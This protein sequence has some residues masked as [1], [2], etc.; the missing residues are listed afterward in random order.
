MSSKLEIT[1]AIAAVMAIRNYGLESHPMPTP[2]MTLDEAVSVVISPYAYDL[3]FDDLMAEAQG[4]LNQKTFNY[5]EKW[6]SYLKDLIP[7]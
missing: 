6:N 5:S 7:C 1:P 4:W 2:E 3:P